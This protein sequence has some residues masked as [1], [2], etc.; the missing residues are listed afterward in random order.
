MIGVPLHYDDGSIEGWVDVH[1]WQGFHSHNMII[2]S[3]GVQHTNLWKFSDW[4]K[5]INGVSAPNI[6]WAAVA[7][8]VQRKRTEAQDTMGYLLKHPDRPQVY[9]VIGG[10]ALKVPSV[11]A[12]MTLINEGKVLPVP[13]GAPIAPGGSWNDWVGL[14]GDEYL[15]M[16]N[17]AA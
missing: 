4:N 5:I 9:Y 15:T 17:A 14:R 16:F 7:A 2:P 8:Y 6:D 10:R 1:Y 11:A 3:S 12:I 13:K